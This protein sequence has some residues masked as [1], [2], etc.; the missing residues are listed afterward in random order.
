MGPSHGPPNNT[1]P[2]PPQFNRNGPPPSMPNPMQPN[3]MIPNWDKP[4]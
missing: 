3:N 1:Y 2:Y 4:P